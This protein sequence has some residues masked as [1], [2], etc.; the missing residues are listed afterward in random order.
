MDETRVPHIGSVE[1]ID[2]ATEITAPNEPRLESV[3]H[4]DGG[5]R[6]EDIENNAHGIS[7]LETSG[8][9]KNSFTG[10]KLSTL[11]DIAEENA[12]RYGLDTVQ[13]VTDEN[14]QISEG[15]TQLSPGKQQTEELIRNTVDLQKTVRVNGRSRIQYVRPE[16]IISEFVTVVPPKNSVSSTENKVT[17]PVAEKTTSHQNGITSE[18]AP[19]SMAPV[20][21]PK[22]QDVRMAN[23]EQKIEGRREARTATTNIRKGVLDFE[24]RSWK[25]SSLSDIGEAVTEKIE[26]VEHEKATT[27]EATPQ[28]KAAEPVVPAKDQ[29][30][31][32]IVGPGSSPIEPTGDSQTKIA[33]A[34]ETGQQGLAYNGEDVLSEKPAD[35]IKPAANEVGSGETTAAVENASVAAQDAPAQLNPQPEVTAGLQHDKPA[36]GQIEK[37]QPIEDVEAQLNALRT[38]QAS[39]VAADSHTE[40]TVGGASIPEAKPPVVD[41]DKDLQTQTE[42]P[43]LTPTL[44]VVDNQT[45]ATTVAPET[46]DTANK[47][48]S[49]ATVGQSQ[50]SLMERLKSL[51]FGTPPNANE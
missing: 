14:V 48:N 41:L 26:E 6:D 5:H 3:L 1:M 49:E 40:N 11:H 25:A 13:K 20:E 16:A 47:E 15:D 10:P 7:M 31:E 39:A 37:T 24:G 44:P 19:V 29:V 46:A 50:N 42:S 27:E 21:A 28:I 22:T 35:D 8:I 36:E 4:K 34:E 2:P 17:E 12:H 43:V 38:E 33:S 30:T 32:Q 18:N 23:I 9:I 51:L 45:A